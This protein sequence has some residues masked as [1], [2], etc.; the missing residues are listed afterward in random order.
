MEKGN[1]ESMVRGV[2]TTEVKFVISIIVFC[3]GVVAPYYAMRQDIA[4]IQRDIAT[5][6]SNHEAHIQ[7]IL[8]EIKEIKVKDETLQDMIVQNQ[9]TIIM[10]QSR[11]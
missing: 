11:Q 8:Q 2:L 5:I 7:D 6:N 4:L 9:K 1:A 10:L 3:A